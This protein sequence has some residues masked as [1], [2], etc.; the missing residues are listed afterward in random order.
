[1]TTTRS[2]FPRIDAPRPVANTEHRRV[3]LDYVGDVEPFIEADDSCSSMPVR[4]VHDQAAGFH[5]EVGPY[6]LFGRD[7]GV[8]RDALASYDQATGVRA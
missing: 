3:I 5:I 7:I 2:V 1:M 8:L 4:V 6:S